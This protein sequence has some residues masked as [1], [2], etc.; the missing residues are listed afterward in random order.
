MI[1]DA[2][3]A[4]GAGEASSDPNMV[5]WESG[6]DPDEFLKTH[7]SYSSDQRLASANA[8]FARERDALTQK[9]GTKAWLAIVEEEVKFVGSSMEEVYQR[10]YRAQESDMPPA[11]WLVVGLSSL[12]SFGSGCRY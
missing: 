7:A 2:T 6:V 5:D 4:T 3:S 11:A 12:E 1:G 8:F 10:V 9:Y